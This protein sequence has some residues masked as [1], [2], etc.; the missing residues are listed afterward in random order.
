MAVAVMSDIDVVF[1][2]CFVHADPT[3]VHQ[4]VTR[5]QALDNCHGMV[6]W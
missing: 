5:G 1:R 4:K 3:S 2:F 6:L